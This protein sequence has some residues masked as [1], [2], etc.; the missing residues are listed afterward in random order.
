MDPALHLPPALLRAARL[1]ETELKEK[2]VARK[3]TRAVPARP[4][5]IGG[6]AHPVG[7]SLSVSA[8][9][10]IGV[11]LCMERLLHRQ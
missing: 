1:K 6:A 9:M 4:R 5:K 8:R 11:G 2:G 7:P 3:E 10:V